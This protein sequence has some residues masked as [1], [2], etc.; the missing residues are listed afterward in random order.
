[1]TERFST[2]PLPHQVLD[3]PADVAFLLKATLDTYAERLARGDRVELWIEKVPSHPQV[4]YLA[5]VVTGRP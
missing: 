4:G 5:A 2:Y 1:M 3:R